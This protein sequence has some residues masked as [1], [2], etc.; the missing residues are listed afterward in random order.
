MKGLLF[1]GWQLE[2]EGCKQTQPRDTE[3]AGRK[4][5]TLKRASS[6][7]TTWDWESING[8]RITEEER[9]VGNMTPPEK[10]Q[11]T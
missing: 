3:R 6:T 7:Q 11:F 8:N 10:S 4:H 5:T 2:W 1:K 9:K